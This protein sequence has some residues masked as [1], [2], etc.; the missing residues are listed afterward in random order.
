V[1]AAD[2]V[3]RH[4]D[5]ERRALLRALEEQ[6][7]EEVRRAEVAGLLVAGADSHPVA[8]RQAATAGNVFAEDAHSAGQHGASHEGLTSGPKREFGQV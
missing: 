6:V 8:D 4:R 1:F 3:E 7:L 5:V 2:R